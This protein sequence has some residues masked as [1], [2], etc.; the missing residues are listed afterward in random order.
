MM[1]DYYSKNADKFIGQYEAVS[2]G[3]IHKEWSHLI[4]V[5]KS[6]VLDVG[7]GSGRDATWLAEQG[8]EVVAIEPAAILRKKAQQLHPSPAIQWL[9]DTLPSLTKT[10][11]LGITF[12]IILLSAVWIHIPPS[13]RSRAFRKLANLL[14]PGGKLIISLRHGESPDNRVMHP[15]SSDELKSLAKDHLLNVIKDTT[16]QDRMG[17]S[18]VS[19]STVVFEL[20]DDGT[21]SLPLLRHVIINDRKASTYKLALLRVILRI[22]DGSPGAVVARDENY[23]S[24]PF[25][26]VALYW[27]K[28]FKGLIL[29]HDFPQQPQGSGRLSFDID[30]FRALSEISLYDLRIG[31]CFSGDD[32]TNL[33]IALREARNNIKRNPAYFTT[34]PSDNNQVFTCDSKQVRAGSS[35]IKLD[36]DFLSKFGTFHIPRYIWESMSRYACWIEPAIKN[37]WC[38][39]MA[40]YDRRA[41]IVRPLED[42][43]KALV[44]L[45]QERSTKEVRHII[46]KI[47]SSGKK[48]C[49]VWTGKELTQSYDVDHCFP[50]SYWSNNDLWNL[51][52]SNPKANRQKSDKLPSAVLLEKSQD[53]IFNWWD[54]AYNGSEY[55]D[56]FI[57]EASAALPVINRDSGSVGF[58]NV[59]RGIQH[60][61]RRL[62]VDQQLIEWEG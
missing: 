20:S 34:F 5:T 24:I 21:G 2:A 19:W 53:A 1:I 52:P 39:L 61:R 40:D 60:Q 30:E 22:A 15:C 17:R 59:F 42:Y 13:D 55:E 46:E 62:K 58:E 45:D 49:C 10:Y 41:G 12:D 38:G 28:M 35:G 33:T 31:A 43:L 14:N 44:W 16:S 4:P 11:K 29:D 3:D 23:V 27:V 25:G 32:A 37:E 26:I 57:V 48:V 47:R 18:A 50:F 6:L 36:L 9:D 8:H 56:R 54:N 51:M 7:A